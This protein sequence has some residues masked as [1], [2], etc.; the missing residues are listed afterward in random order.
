MRTAGVQTPPP[1]VAGHDHVGPGQG[2]GQ[3]AEQLALGVLGEFAVVLLVVAGGELAAGDQPPL[4][5]RTPA[6]HGHEVDADAEQAQRLDE[7]RAALVVAHHADEPDA[8]A[9]RHQVGGGVGGAAGSVLGGLQ[10]HHG[11]RRL[12]GE[13][14]GRATEPRVEH[15]VAD[16]HGAGDLVCAHEGE[17]PVKSPAQTRH[18][19]S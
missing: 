16:D 14:L 12:L 7:R 9:E 15:D 10:A 6:G 1:V 11:H 13:T 4:V 18:I 3:P 5:R 8:G 2:V 19:G 17:V